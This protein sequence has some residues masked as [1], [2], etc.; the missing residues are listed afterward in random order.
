[1]AGATRREPEVYHAPSLRPRRTA[2]SQT[3]AVV[4]AVLLI[5]IA[6]RVFGV[7]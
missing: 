6:L 5:L 4:V 3:L 2:M 1:M 7:V